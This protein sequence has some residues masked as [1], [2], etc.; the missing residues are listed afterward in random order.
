MVEQQQ[1]CPMPFGSKSK[2][3]VTRLPTSLL[4]PGCLGSSCGFDRTS[5]RSER[6]TTCTERK[7]L[8]EEC[9]GKVATV[10]TRREKKPC[11]IKTVKNRLDSDRPSH[12]RRLHRLRPC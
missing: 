5:R 7:S 2:R 1:P 4:V 10:A 3:R 8:L 6:A 12:G 11:S 9:G